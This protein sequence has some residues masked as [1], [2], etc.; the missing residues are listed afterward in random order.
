MQ[1]SRGFIPPKARGGDIVTD[2]D[3]WEQP[4]ALSGS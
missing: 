3:R 2:T 4:E 1:V